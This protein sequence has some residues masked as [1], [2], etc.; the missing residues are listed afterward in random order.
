M[1]NETLNDLF[2][3]K[4][5]ALYDIEQQL[6]KA[7][8]KM[9]KN[10]QHPDLKQA[11]K[12]HLEETKEQAKRLEKIF[13]LLGVRPQKTLVE[14]IR[15]LVKDAQWLI[16]HV[17]NKLARDASLISAAQYVEHYEMAGYGTA[18]EW[19]KDLGLTE[20]EQLLDETLK[21]EI[22]ADEKLNSI[23]VSQVNQ[24]VAIAVQM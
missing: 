17:K 19:A 16:T 8:P 24:E 1:K 18:K 10:A 7:L 22:A 2:L 15:G 4:I 13:D 6:I 12:D 5:K 20:A 3:L 14:A 21:E 11:F 9:A 23:A